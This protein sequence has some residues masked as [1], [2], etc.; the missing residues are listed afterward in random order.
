MGDVAERLRWAVE[1]LA[2]RPGETL[3]EIGCGHGV[4]VTLLSADR[5]AGRIA[6]CDRSA[7]MV[8][9]ARRRNRAAITAGQVAIHHGAVEMLAC[10]DAGFDTVFACNV[11]PF[12]RGDPVPALA[13]AGRLLAP[14]GRLCLFHGAPL[15]MTSGFATGL[16]TILTAH[17]FTI[18]D[19]IELVLHQSRVGMLAARLRSGG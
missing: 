6:A 17:G 1:R 2:A 11:P 3:F 10:E 7:S 5:T 13:A 9:A 16:D 19:R 8:T 15:A 12:L 4:A 14:G 18:E